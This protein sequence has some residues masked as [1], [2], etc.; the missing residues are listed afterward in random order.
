MRFILQY[1][2]QPRIEFGR[3]RVTRQRVTTTFFTECVS[4]CHS[5]ARC[6]FKWSRLVHQSAGIYVCSMHIKH[7]AVPPFMIASLG[8]FSLHSINT[9]NSTLAA[10]FTQYNLHNHEKCASSIQRK[11]ECECGTAQQQNIFSTA[12]QQIRTKIQQKKNPAR[13]RITSGIYILQPR[14]KALAHHYYATVE[15]TGDKY[16]H[17]QH[18]TT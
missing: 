12:L 1:M 14:I 8:K 18:N 17:T 6:W 11:T 5:I 3:R 7:M 9:F 15:S 10:N 4:R 2:R 13:K 16:R